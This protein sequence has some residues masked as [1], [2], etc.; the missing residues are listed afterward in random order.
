MGKCQIP[1]GSRELIPGVKG[2]YLSSRAGRGLGPSS[3]PVVAC[4]IG[5]A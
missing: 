2:Q 3:F 5:E 4:L 1:M